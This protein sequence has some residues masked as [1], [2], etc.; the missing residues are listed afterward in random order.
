[1]ELNWE[2]G[3]GHTDEQGGEVMKHSWVKETGLANLGKRSLCRGQ[4]SGGKHPRGG[5]CGG[6]S[7]TTLSPFVFSTPGKTLPLPS[8]SEALEPLLLLCPYQQ[9]SFIQDVTHSGLP[10]V[11]KVGDA[12]LL[13]YSKGGLGQVLRE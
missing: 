10:S 8:G 7:L 9:H 3:L 1:M 4:S 6:Q 2:A 5:I 12:S 13:P 11:P